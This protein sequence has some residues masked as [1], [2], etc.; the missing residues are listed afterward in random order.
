[1][2]GSEL[3]KLL[4]VGDVVNIAFGRNGKWRRVFEGRSVYADESIF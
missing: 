2:V 1:M 3:V 4:N